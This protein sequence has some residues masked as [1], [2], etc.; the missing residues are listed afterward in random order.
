MPDTAAPP[1]LLERPLPGVAL[2]RLNRP[3]ATNA[4]SL[5]L[6]ALLSQHFAELGADPAVRCIC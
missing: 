6:Q 4:L 2:L 5:E 1:V 3:H